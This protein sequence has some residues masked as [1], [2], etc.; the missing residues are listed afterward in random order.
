MT[1]TLEIFQNYLNLN[2]IRDL[3]ILLLAIILFFALLK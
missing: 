2:L 3:L 1:T